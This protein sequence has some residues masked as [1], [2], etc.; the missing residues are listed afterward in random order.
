MIPLKFF[1]LAVTV[2]ILIIVVLTVIIYRNRKKSDEIMTVLNDIESGYENRK[3]LSKGNGS[4][5]QICFKINK[6]MNDSRCKIVELEK[7]ERAYKKLMT[8]LSHDVRT[9]LTSLIGYLDA[10]HKNIVEGGEREAYIN[11]ARDKAYQLKELTDSLFEWVKLDSKAQVYSFENVDANELTRSI[12]I[13]W[14]PVLEKKSINFTVDIPETECIL[15]LD[16]GAY[17]RIVN[18]IIQN[19]VTHS[20]CSK[21]SVGI[22]QETDSAVLSISD[23]GT[24]IQEKDIPFVFHRLYKCDESRSR[25]GNGLGL[26]IVR[27]LVAAHGGTV[28]AES[29]PNEKTTFKV[30]FPSLKVL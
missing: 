4:S 12:F 6:I 5:A 3:I 28:S 13:A 15:K 16:S 18:N 22:R 23:N 14:I 29:I 20:Q 7:S 26:S 27:E 17:G 30:V 2:M 24:G 19:A 25:K 21:L 10:L 1:I 9:P 11:I 8:D